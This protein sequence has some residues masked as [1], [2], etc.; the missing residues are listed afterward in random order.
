MA[1]DDIL[2]NLGIVASVY[3]AAQCVKA[4]AAAHA[5]FLR[6]PK[7]LRKYG[8]WAVVTGATDGIGR[9]YAFELAKQGLNVLLISRSE[10]K[11]KEVEK[12]L[13]EKYSKVQVAHHAVD[14][15]NFDA[16]AREGVKAKIAG[17]EVGVLINNV[18]L[19]YPFTKYFHELKDDEVAG[20]VDVN[21]NSTVWMTRLVLGDTNA[22]MIARKRGAIV[23][24]SSAAGRMT[25]PLLAEYSGAKGFIENFS[26]SLKAELVPFKIDVQCQAPLFVATKMAKIRKA[27]LT[28]PSP[29]SYAKAAVAHIGFEDSVSPYWSH[30]LQLCVQ[31]Q[32]PEFLSNKLVGSMHLGIRKAGMKKEARQ[33]EEGKKSQ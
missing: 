18:G 25:S 8:E 2:R 28:V 24:T 31:R 19:S 13:K 29:A 23:N 22:G 21:V 12:E 27:S 3:I 26:K 10:D 1:L 9:A 4:V 6:G 11:L 14:F 20:I 32:L 17:L 15:S 5:F 16:K 33:A 7:K 30:A